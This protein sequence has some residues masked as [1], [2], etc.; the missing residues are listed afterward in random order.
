MHC[1]IVSLIEDVHA[2]AVAT[3]LA[4]Q[5]HSVLLW[6]M[7]ADSASHPASVELSG[8]GTQWIV[9]GK[10]IPLHGFDTIWLRR[11]RQTRP[12]SYLHHDDVEFATKEANAFY[13]AFWSVAGPQTRW[14]N[15]PAAANAAEEKPLQLMMAR[16]VGFHTPATL[17]SNDPTQI[18][19]FIDA[20]SR[21]GKQT[22]YKTFK[23]AGW[24]DGDEV[25][26]KYTS[27][28]RIDDVCA[29]ATVGAVPGIYQEKLSKRFEVRATF[30]GKTAYCVTIDS[31]KDAHAVD[32]WRS[33]M[34]MKGLLSPMSLPED[35]YMKCVAFME[36]MGI[37]MG[38]FDFVVSEDGIYYFLEV[39][40]QG[41]FL[42]V[43]EA[44]PELQMLEAFTQFM[45]PRQARTNPI[46][47]SEIFASAR[48]KEISQQFE[49]ERYVYV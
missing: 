28:I 47:V 17:I 13:G 26:L 8:S 43:E 15:A 5:G 40:Q 1:L 44:C 25:R 27:T 6:D 14:L 10:P 23:P 30:F 38:C 3:V 34:N 39:N 37:Q 4:D 18:V 33:A 19:R 24:T 31:Q 41:Q 35:V 16:Q 36:C 29:S 32:D 7:P 46:E 11:R 42:W 45:D 12:P 22:I 21:E 49:A 2:R 20:R 48:Y 9:G